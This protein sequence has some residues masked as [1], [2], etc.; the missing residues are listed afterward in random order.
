MN[1]NIILK[2]IIKNNNKILTQTQGTIETRSMIKE[3]ENCRG[4]VETIWKL[5]LNPTRQLR[6]EFGFFRSILLQIAFTTGFFKISYERAIS[7]FTGSRSIKTGA[8]LI[9]LVKS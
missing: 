6:N 7:T 8:F 1:R 4:N 5:L 9:V 2:Q 3:V